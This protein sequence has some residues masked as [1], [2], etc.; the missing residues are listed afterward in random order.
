MRTRSCRHR[1][2]RYRGVFTI[3]PDRIVRVASRLWDAIGSHHCS[4]APGEAV[5]L[6]ADNETSVTVLISTPI[7]KAPVS[8]GFIKYDVC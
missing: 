8:I 5:P 1:L 4:S 7:I 3:K 2:V 6:V